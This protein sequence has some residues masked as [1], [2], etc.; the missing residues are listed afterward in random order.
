M[1]NEKKWKD[2]QGDEIVI[3]EDGYN[4]KPPTLVH[5]KTSEYGASFDLATLTEIRAHLDLLAR[6]VFGEKVLTVADVMAKIDSL[7]KCDE[8]NALGDYNFRILLEEIKG[9]INGEQQ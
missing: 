7:I 5:I 2:G 1:S 8:L 9:F 3:D 6:D 4:G